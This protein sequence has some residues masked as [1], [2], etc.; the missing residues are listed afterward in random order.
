MRRRRWG[1]CCCCCLPQKRWG[2]RS[3]RNRDGNMIDDVMEE[4]VAE[5]E[6]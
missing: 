5:M 4:M 2:E 1:C 3:R 6:M